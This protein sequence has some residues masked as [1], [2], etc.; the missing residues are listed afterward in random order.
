MPIS[1]NATVYEY[2]YMDVQGR[3]EV[4]KTIKQVNNAMHINSDWD[5][6][7]EFV[8]INWTDEKGDAITD[9]SYV[10]QKDTSYGV[11]VRV[12]AKD[13]EA[14]TIDSVDVVSWNW[15]DKVESKTHW[16]DCRFDISTTFYYAEIKYPQKT[17]GEYF[18]FGET[19]Y[20]SAPYQDYS[21]FN[22]WLGSYSY[23]GQSYTPELDSFSSKYAQFDMPKVDGALKLEAKY[24]PCI[25]EE[26]T[27]D[28]TCVEQ[29]YT[30]DKCQICYQEQN[31]KYLPT[32]E[33]CYESEHYSYVYKK[34][35]TDKDGMVINP[36]FICGKNQSFTI[37]KVSKITLLQTAYIYDG[38]NHKPAVSVK[39]SLG[40]KLSADCYTVSTPKTA[41]DVGTYK[42][43]VKLK[44]SNYA[45][46]KTLTYKINPKNTTGFKLSSLKKGFKVSW[47]KYTKQTTGYQ[48][49]YSTNK[50]FKNSKIVTTSKNTTT[51]M[52]FSKKKSNQKY[53]VRIRTYKTVNKTKYYSTWSNTKTV[54][55][56]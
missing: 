3:P 8:C 21:H 53:Y 49:E 54:T 31:I 1:A 38:K 55:T 30:C 46:T 40:D 18:A 27:Q 50:N 34:A 32:G 39:N 48:I 10:F 23:N 16:Q 35:T 29:G 26:Y 25:F 11:S 12:R 4:N 7:W 13:Y 15:S 22:I 45:G 14:S 36:C 47:N 2:V 17:V 43:T 28:S 9:D 52:K 20:L 42:V 41:K 56:K 51:W 19:L 33:H 37:N 24:E 5:S 6:K 44:G